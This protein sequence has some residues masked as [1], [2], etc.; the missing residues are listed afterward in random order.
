MDFSRNKYNQTETE[1]ISESAIIEKAKKDINAFAPIYDKYYVSIFR[2]IFNR[3]ETEE[4]AADITSQVF[5]KAIKSIKKYEDRGLP[6]GS[7]LYRI[8]RNEIILEARNNKLNIVSSA[9]TADIMNIA[10]EIDC[11]KEEK[12]NKM[13]SL[14]ESLK[15]SDFELIEMKYFEKR[16]YKEIAEILNEKETNLKVRV[17]RIIQKMKL[18]VVNE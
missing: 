17:H 13:M 2:Y 3:V 12:F 16:S 6:Y 4:I 10:D 15:S 1:I 8:A 18:L 9:K 11:D 5:Y 14:L 7:F